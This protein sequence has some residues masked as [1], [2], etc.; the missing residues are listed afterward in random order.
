MKYD[1]IVISKANLKGR[2][3]G[4]LKGEPLLIIRMK[5]EDKVDVMNLMGRPIFNVPI[6][7]LK[8]N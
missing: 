8:E 3:G 7:M 1:D 5:G 6:N 2:F 4:C